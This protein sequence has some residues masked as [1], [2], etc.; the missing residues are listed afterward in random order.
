MNELLRSDLP[1]VQP[2]D[3]LDVVLEK[4]SAHDVHSLA[5]LEPRSGRVRGLITRSRLMARYQSVLHED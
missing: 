3:P 4:F 5:V 1:T 2:E